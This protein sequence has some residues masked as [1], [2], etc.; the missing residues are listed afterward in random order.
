MVEWAR[1]DEKAKE[2]DRDVIRNMPDILRQAG[3]QIL[4]LSSAL[5]SP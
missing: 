1:L 5:P 4:R 3:M 2:K